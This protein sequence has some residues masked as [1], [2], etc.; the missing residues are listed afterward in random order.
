MSRRDQR[1]AF[2]L[3][4]LLV[5]VAI[6][7][8]LISIL[9]PS[10]SRARDQ[11]RT[12][13]CQT[14]IRQLLIAS[15][16][17]SVE[18]RGLLPGTS[19]DAHADWLGGNNFGP[20]KSRRQ[21]QD[22][23]IWKYMGQQVEAYKCP[24]D[25]R[26]QKFY[27]SYTANS[28]LSG[29]NPEWLANAHYRDEGRLSS[30]NYHTTD[31]RRSLKTIPVPLFIEEDQEYWLLGVANSAWDNEDS[32]IQRHNGRKYGNVGN[33]DGSVARHRLPVKPRTPGRYFTSLSHCIRGRNK[34]VTGLIWGEL[35]QQGAYGAFRR[36]RDAKNYGVLH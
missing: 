2:T 11:A 15:L 1:K 26:Q 32:L 8:M 16:S 31:H 28:L 30:M 21:P 7:A 5:V 10:L 22:G 6:I 33:T 24:M 12:V 34:Y 3:I 14:N 23:V 18:S 13:V 4:E 17:Y 25:R 19:Y 9:L 29:A 36:A 35:S 20:G 27:Y